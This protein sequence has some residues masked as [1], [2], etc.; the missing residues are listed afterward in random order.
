MPIK[1][2]I[3][4]FHDLGQLFQFVSKNDAIPVDVNKNFNTST[5]DFEQIMHLAEIKNPWFTPENIQYCLAQWGKL[6]TLDNLNNWQK[7]T[8]SPHKAK[9]VGIIMAGNIPL[10]GLHDLLSVLIAGHSVMV[11]TSSKDDVLMSFVLDFLKNHSEDLNRSISKVERMQRPE[12]VIA[13]GSDNTARYFEFYFKDIPHII[14]KNRTSIAVLDGQESAED[15]KFLAEDIFR[16]FGLGCRN[17]T[18]LY[19]PEGFVL[20]RLFEAFYEWETIIHHHKYANNYNY[21]R[22]IYLMSKD[23]FFDNN[24]VLLKHSNAMYSPI[25]VVNFVH[26]KDLN[27]VKN[28]LDQ[29]QEK[30]QCIVGNALS[31]YDNSVRFGQTQKPGLVDYADGV[32]VLKFLNAL[33]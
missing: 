13:T 16:Y 26:Y 14:R 25:G 7:K 22:T 28:S 19:L 23:E 31:D 15:L 5:V 8:P 10:V 18:Q 33:T 2:R 9:T 21:N 24:F 32:D 3:S 4:A 29:N 6:L 27:E 12:A 1:H 11:K 30:L 20:D 17:V